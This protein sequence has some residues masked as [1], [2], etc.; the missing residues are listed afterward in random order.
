MGPLHEDQYIFFIIPRS[1]LLRIR[2]ISEHIVEEI[3]THI[4]CSVPFYENPAVLWDN[5]EKCSRARQAT[6]ENMAL[7]HFMPDT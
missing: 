2:N 1:V 3:K 6:D 7:A 4:L 5:V